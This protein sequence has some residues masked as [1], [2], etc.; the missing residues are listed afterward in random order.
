[1]TG[2]KSNVISNT[3]DSLF[4]GMNHLIPK[5]INQSYMYYHSLTIFASKCH[6]ITPNRSQIVGKKML[7]AYLG[8][9]S[10]FQMSEID[11]LVV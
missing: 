8:S 11:I 1:M 10:E 4:G 7:I 3:R 5:N 2:F 6:K 9:I